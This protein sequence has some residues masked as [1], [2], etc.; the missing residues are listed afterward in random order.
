MLKI[1]LV[2]CGFHEEE[3]LS[4]VSEL[5]KIQMQKYSAEGG[6]KTEDKP[7]SVLVGLVIDC[8]SLLS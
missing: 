6:V 4:A 8:L 1:K 7:K 2:S 3:A 5:I